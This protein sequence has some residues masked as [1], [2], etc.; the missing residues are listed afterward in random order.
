MSRC[1]VVFL[2]I[3][4][5][6]LSAFTQRATMP[7]PA[8]LTDPNSLSNPCATDIFLNANRKNPAFKKAE[9]RMNAQILA[10]SRKG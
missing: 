7:F 10:Y 3:F 4:L 1:I 6:G 8:L 2:L 5:S 9:D